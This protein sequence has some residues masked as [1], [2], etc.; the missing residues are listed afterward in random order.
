M[1]TLF[2]LLYNL[3][4][5]IS[6]SIISGFIGHRNKKGL[7]RSIL[8]GLIFGIAAVIGMLHPLVI[9]PGLIFDG[10]S[11]MISLSGLFF[12]PLASAIAAS[13]A[14]I[15]R[16]IQGGT[17]LI[18][19]TIV[20]V[21]SASIGAFLNIKNRRKNTEIT[22]NMIFL[23]GII[24]HLIMI[25]LMFTLPGGIGVNIV[26][27]LGIPIII[28]YPLATVL[29]G[30]ILLESNERSRMVEELQISNELLIESENQLN[31]AL[32]NA[33]VPIMLRTEDGEVLKL[34]RKWTEITGYTIQDIPT[35]DEWTKKAYG[36]D[37]E[38]IQALINDSYKSTSTKT[39]REQPIIIADGGVRI[40]EFNL[41]II[42]KL[43]DGRRVTMSAATD[44][45]DRIIAEKTLRASEEKYRLITEQASDVIWVYNITKE[46][47]TYVSPSIFALR[48]LTVEQAM[49]ES[50]EDSLPGESGVSLLDTITVNTKSFLNNPKESNFYN[51]EIQQSCKNGDIIWIEVS[52]KYRFNTDGDIEIVGVSRNI[53]E[54]KKLENEILY[55]SY[56]DHLTGL[57]NRRFYEIELARLNTKRNL[58][59][60]IIM[61]DVNGLKL[62]NDKFGH[63]VGDE[64]LKKVADVI[65]KGCRA[66]DIIARLGGDE[67]VILLPNTDNYEADIMIKRINNLLLKEKITQGEINISV[68]FGYETKINDVEKIE[69]VFKR[70]EDFMYKKKMNEG[71]SMRRSDG[72]Q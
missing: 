21:L 56:K 19:A 3:G 45:T 72:I 7:E 11:V 69:E 29:I 18:M 30:R 50:I 36:S 31:S 15:I 64:L 67:F 33:A 12:G 65:K 39:F 35:V 1:E 57:Y 66:D 47:Y 48:G 28:A 58:P 55:L 41:S 26:K 32:D 62:I 44:V 63:A 25:L 51:I 20:I 4:I 17:G 9:A 68:S 6:I 13:M 46:K 16:I 37:K 71:P 60:T 2:E 10:R 53:E 14:L 70:A 27:L 43:A 5:L 54:R 24:V 42:G 22:I 38:K 8:Q 49:N 59:L 23:M 61:G 34:S 40:W 52:S